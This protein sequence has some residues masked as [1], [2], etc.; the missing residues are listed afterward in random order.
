MK[1]KLISFVIAQAPGFGKRGIKEVQTQTI[2]SAPHYFEASVPRQFLVS[3]EKIIIG[4]REGTL[5]LK[6][7][8]PDI[9]LAE[10]RFEFPD[11]LSDNALEF[12]DLVI[13]ECYAL[14]NKKGAKN[15]ENL[16]E[17]Y[18]V[19]L[20]SNYEGE[21]E[22]FLIH[23]QNIVSFLK[24]E[25]LALDIPEIE[26]T[27]KSQIKYAK[28]D[29]V[30]VDWDG[31]F[32]FDTEGDFESNL[33]LLELANLQLL[34]YRILDKW[35]D[36]RL[37]RLIELI[38]GAPPKTRFLFKAKDINK[39]LKDTMLVRVQS[40]SEF[41]TLDM[42]IKLI[43]DWYSARLFD[44][45]ARKFKLETWHSGIKEKI[46]AVEDVYEVASE[47][48]TVTWEHRSRIIEMIGWYV[49]LV[50]WMVLLILDIYFY[51]N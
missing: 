34:K 19:G 49:L 9:L 20:I 28:N 1:A 21:P 46:D 33:E 7:Y 37:Q 14:L 18:S 48:F 17:E 43:G 39:A 41:Q 50:G 3:E 2:E 51:K 29:L 25:K 4:N 27:L 5:A 6:M 32:I 45:N 31:A 26:Y 11:I 15:V 24:S 35:L 47:N 38:A 8:K 10:A 44:L 42:E 40:I 30:I 12:K 22:Q 13:D 16:S 23:R 36:A